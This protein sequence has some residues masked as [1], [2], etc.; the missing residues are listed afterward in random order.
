VHLDVFERPA[1]EHR[2]VA[3]GVDGQ[4]RRQGALDLFELGHHPVNHFDGVAA[5]LLADR[6]T[7]CRHATETGGESHFLHAVLDP[8]DV[9]KGDRRSVPVGQDDP[10]E[11]VD[12]DDAAHC[13]QGDFGRSRRKVAA[14]D[15]DVLALDGGS[16]LIDR[17]TVGV[18]AVGVEQQLDF[19]LT[20][21]VET[22]RADALERF[23]NLLDLLV[24]DFADLFLIARAVKRQGHDRL[25]VGIDLLDDRRLGVAGKLADD[26]R[27][28]VAHV[29][30]RRF[31]VAFKGEID[32]DAG[33]A[34]LGRGAQ[35]VDAAD[36]VDHF[37]DA[38]GQLRLD[39]FSAG[40]G[41]GHLHRHDR[42][43]GLR[44][45]VEP[46]IPV[47]ERPHDDQRGRHHQREDRALN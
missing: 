45:Q 33:E 9:G 44:H 29:L 28:L 18:H 4:I 36:G 27:D 6:N 35:L 39:L 41:Q 23:E 10:V 26:G 34:E 19:A 12:V 13:S 14:W 37:L 46:E 31:N 7:N 43:V 32:H 40:A 3:A 20:L 8:S 16:H 21:A 22:D 42:H 24:G 25:R 30:G 5:G 38:L 11:V 17:E 1:D 2:L 15:L 47:G